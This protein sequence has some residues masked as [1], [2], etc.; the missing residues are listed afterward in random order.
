MKYFAYGS[1][2][3]GPVM[4]AACAEHRF[5]GP[6]RL[7]GYRLAFLRR[8]V[9]TGTGVAD[10]ALDPHGNVWGA[11]YE[12][13]RSELGALDRKETLG[14]GYEHLDVVVQTRDGE[15]H[16]AMAYSVI[17]KEPVEIRPSLAY[18]QGLIQGAGERSL[19]AEYLA[20]LQALVCA[21]NLSLA[22]SSALTGRADRRRTTGS[23]RERRSSAAPLRRSG[24]R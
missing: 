1:N 16:R 9:R 17:A 14:S 20:S 18:V 8:S 23:R 22:G 24:G 13:E 6:A 5:L 4:Q 3:S 21:W 11:L 7:P 2:M 10:I 12:L 15:S 19:P